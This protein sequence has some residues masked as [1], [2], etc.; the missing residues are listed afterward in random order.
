MILFRRIQRRHTLTCVALLGLG[1]C[2]R[3][4]APARADST[5]SESV[6]NVDSVATTQSRNWDRSA[7]PLLLVAA[8]APS[9]AFIVVPDSATA[10]STLAAIPHP[11]SVTLFSRG[12]TVQEAELP[13]VAD[14]GLCTVA[15]LNA[16]PPPRPWN[17]GFIGG[18]VSPLPIDSIETLSRSDSASLVVWMNRLASGIP[19]D[20]AGRFAG[21]PFVVRNIWRFTLPSGQQAVVSNLSRQINQEASPLSESTFL[22][23]ERPASDTTFSTEYYERSFGAE[24]TLQSRDVLAGALIGANRNPALVIVRDFGDATAYGII[25]R[26]DDSKWRARWSSARRRCAP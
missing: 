4:K 22:V 10:G 8:D 1:A 7:G 18:V 26:G 13:A 12:G 6:A 9:R 3:A 15:S 16:A 19:N 24:E 2:E 25:E 5:A 23:A 17:V 21:L 11:A 20:S 14:S